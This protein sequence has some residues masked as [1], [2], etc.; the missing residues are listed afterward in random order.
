MKPQFALLVFLFPLKGMYRHLTSTIICYGLIAVAS[1]PFAG[2]NLQLD[3]FR[4]LFRTAAYAQEAT[5]LEWGKNL[6]L[7]SAMTR[8]LGGTHIGELRLLNA[9]FAVGVLAYSLK[10][11]RMPY[12][13]SLFIQRFAYDGCPLFSS[14]FLCMKSITWYCCIYPSCLFAKL[15]FLG[16]F[17]QGHSL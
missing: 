6:S 4:A 1:I 7:L 9:V 13:A 12:N 16:R 2:F 15:A 11:F 3:Y 5:M 17:W 14:W 10:K 8:L